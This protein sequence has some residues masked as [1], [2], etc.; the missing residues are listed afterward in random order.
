MSSPELAAIGSFWAS[1]FNIVIR[2]DDSDIFDDVSFF[3]RMATN[4]N[5][6]DFKTPVRGK[7]YDIPV[8]YHRFHAVPLN[9]KA[10]TPTNNP[11]KYF[12]KER[13]F[14]LAS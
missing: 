8:T 12:P 13:N 4:N 9:A 6:S 2:G 11:S 10:P 1:K 7:K 5:V 3:E 14:Q